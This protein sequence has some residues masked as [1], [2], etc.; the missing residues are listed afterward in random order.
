M[1]GVHTLFLQRDNQVLINSQDP[2]RK[3]NNPVVLHI[4]LAGK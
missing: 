2:G 1:E 3:S 4:K